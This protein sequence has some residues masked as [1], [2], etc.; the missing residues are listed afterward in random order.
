MAVGSYL[1][2]LSSGGS[3]SDLCVRKAIVVAK[4]E[5]GL[6]AG[7]LGKEQESW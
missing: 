1:R 6:V 4:G 3:L 2:L 5:P 7:G